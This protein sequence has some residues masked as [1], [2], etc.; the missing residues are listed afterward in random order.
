[1]HTESITNP[2]SITNT[3]ESITNTDSVTIA[4]AKDSDQDSNEE[5]LSED[6]KELD[7][8]LGTSGAD[9]RIP[10]ETFPQAGTPM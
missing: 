6:E 8:D 4:S 2:E 5:A 3:E 10:D 9:T 7:A 1:M